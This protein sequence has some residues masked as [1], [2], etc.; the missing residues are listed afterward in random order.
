GR[1]GCPAPPLRGPPR[2]RPRRVRAAPRTPHPPPPGRRGTPGRRRALHPPQ[3]LPLLPPPRRREMRRLHPAPPRRSAPLSR[4]RLDPGVPVARGFRPRA[5]LSPPLGSTPVSAGRAAVGHSGVP[6][7]SPGGRLA[8]LRPPVVKSARAE[9]AHRSSSLILALRGH[10]SAP[11]PPQRQDQ[12]G[13]GATHHP[14]PPTP[15]MPPAAAT[16]ASRA[17]ENRTGSGTALLPETARRQS[18]SERSPGMRSGAPGRFALPTAAGRYRERGRSPG[19]P[20]LAGT[21]G[22]PV[23][24]F[25]CGSAGRDGAVGNRGRPPAEPPGPRPHARRSPE[26]AGAPCRRQGPRPAAAFRSGRGV[27]DGGPGRGP[28]DPWAEASPDRGRRPVELSRLTRPVR[29]SLRP[30]GFARCP[31]RSE[32]SAGG[33]G[34]AEARDP[35]PGTVFA[36]V[37]TGPPVTARIDRDG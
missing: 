36:Q 14:L 32:R 1:R 10:R 23:T 37:S 24:A 20:A 35:V 7:G 27:G 4:L 33:G 26:A 12:R 15:A 5:A 6:A 31:G 25:R 17:A 18:P 2:G 28:A 22:R 29:F 34:A 11:M 19:P 9:G 21:T 30:C 13:S 16:A 8:L 3:L